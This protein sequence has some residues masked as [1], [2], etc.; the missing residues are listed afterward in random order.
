MDKNKIISEIKKR[1]KRI[2]EL[3][4]K[5]I[6]LF[7]SYSQNTQEPESDID[8]LVKFAEGKKTFDNYMDL[9]FLLED[10]F[11]RNVD[12]V[13]EENIKPGLQKSILKSVEYAKL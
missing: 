9:K 3:G 7:G 4:V 12:L 8:I 1:N 10:L 5:E 11:N 13:I 6:G 2:Q